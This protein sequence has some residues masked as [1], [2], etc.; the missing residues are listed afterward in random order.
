MWWSLKIQNWMKTNLVM[1][2]DICVYSMRFGW[3]VLGFSKILF[4]LKVVVSLFTKQSKE[5]YFHVQCI[6]NMQWNCI[7]LHSKTEKGNENKRLNFKKFNN[8]SFYCQKYHT[9]STD[10]F[11]FTISWN[12]WFNNV[13]RRTLDP[14]R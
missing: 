10:S 13:T 7:E 4:I 6:S 1:Y 8:V 2:C 14:W 9:A 12:F 5:A 11:C 3:Y